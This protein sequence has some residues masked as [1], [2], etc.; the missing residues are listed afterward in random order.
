MDIKIYLLTFS[1]KTEESLSE[2]IRHFIQW[3]DR[4]QTISLLDLS[5]SLNARREH[6]KI[7]CA[8]IVQTIEDLFGQ[9]QDI[10]FS[11][12]NSNTKC[13]ICDKIKPVS[14]IWWCNSKRFT[15][16]LPISAI[17]ALISE[18]MEKSP[19]EEIEEKSEETTKV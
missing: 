15:K 1:A 11:N 6:F 17:D 8:F 10:N 2:Y 18:I 12:V 4:E 3:L 13:S 19:P 14:G 9:L 5:Y 7:R 16:R